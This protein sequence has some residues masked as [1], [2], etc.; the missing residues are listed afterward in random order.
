[1]MNLTLSHSDCRTHIKVFF[2]RTIDGLG[3]SIDGIYDSTNTCLFI[4][5]S[6]VH[7]PIPYSYALAY[8]A[9]ENM[10]CMSIK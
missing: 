8:R 5:Q 4:V 6:T 2:P 9:Y 10:H 1:M 7:A 3:L